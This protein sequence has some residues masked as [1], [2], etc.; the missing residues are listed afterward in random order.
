MV[1]ERLIHGQR[2]DGCQSL[3]E[4][5]RADET[6]SRNLSGD[7]RCCY[8]SWADFVAKVGFAAVLTASAAF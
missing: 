2:L 7:D 6:H 1:T 8:R 3:S 4:Q 5:Q